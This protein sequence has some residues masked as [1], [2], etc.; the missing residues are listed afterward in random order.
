MEHYH[1]SLQLFADAGTLVNATGSYVNAYDGS[2]SSF[3]GRDSL[4]AEMKDFYD[5]ELLENARVEQI[6]A[7]FAKR[8]T[9][10]KNHRGTVEWRKWNTFEPA[11]KLVEGVIPTGQK[12][13][14]SK[15]TGSVDQYGTYT[16]ITD[17]LELR[18]YDDV[19]LGAT[20]EMGA[21]AAETQEKLI[22]DALAVG[23]NVLYCDKITIANGTATAVT[24]QQGLI[25]NA[26]YVSHLTPEMVNRA[27]TILK[28]NRVPKIGGKYVAVIHPSVA[29]DLRNSDGW[30]EA[31]KYAAPEELF[32]GE[33]GELHGVR[34]I[35]DVFAPVLQ[36]NDLAS[37]S[38]S[39]KINKNGGYSGAITSVAFDGGT[40]ADDALIGRIIS[41]NGKTAKVTD[42]T[43]STIT[44]ASTD[45][46][47][48][49][50]D[51]DIFP[52]EGAGEGVA[53]YATYFFGKDGFGIIDPEGGALEMI[54]HDKDEI[55]GPLNQ[56]STIG[57][58][59][60]TNGATILYPE[61]ILRCMSTSSY[62]GTDT[63]N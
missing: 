29:E 33:I 14:V 57:Y 30:L 51:A 22:R 26:T 16:A 18:A 43:S 58:K 45:F 7:Q 62:S 55:G 17:K 47:S 38:R 31:H 46:G 59:F 23:T 24:G 21:S 13:G 39:L 10:P 2:A 42:N 63:A 12:F 60:E 6:Y 27:V 49:S 54:I 3:S 8:Q 61:R 53:A 1:F 5:T 11:S 35:E 44:F 41:I 32:N 28:K 25:E 34:F 37:N 15:L 40:V 20:E 56:F 50:D 36:G 48:I 52:G 9:L 4:S 19:I